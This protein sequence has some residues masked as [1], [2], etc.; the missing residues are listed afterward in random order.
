M[1]ILCPSCFEE[2]ADNAVSCFACATILSSTVT[3][4]SALQAGTLL[5]QGKYKIEKVLDQGGFGITY[6]GIYLQNSVHVAIKE[7]W[8]EAGARQ[9]SKVFWPNSIAP[10]DKQKQIT[11]FQN[12]ASNVQKCSH[13]HIVKVYDWFQENDTAYMVM[14]LLS[15]KPLDKI[16]KEEGILEENRAKHYLLQI[17]DALKVIHANNLLHR[18]IKPGNIIIVPPDNAVLIDFGAAREFIIAGKTAR[19]TGILTAGYAPY[20]Q[21]LSKAQRFPATDFY[22]LC[23][24]MYELLTGKL[25]AE[26]GERAD[27]LI[28]KRPDPF[29]SPRQLNPNLS[30][31]IEK[32]IMTG[33]QFK[34]E[35]RFQTADE[36]IN[37]LNGKF[38]SPIQRKAHELVKQGKLVDAV[39]SYEKLLNNEPNNGQAALELALIQ[40]Y[41]DDKKA[42]LAA[43]KAIQL[44]QQDGRGYGVLG[45]VSCR[46]TNWVE[47]VKYLQQAANLSPQESWIQAN[48]AWALGKSGNWQ[49]AKI[50]VNQALSI[51]ANCTFALGLQAWIYVKQ[52]QWK[53]AVRAA[54]Q[55][56]F[57]LKQ[58]PLTNSKESQKWIYPYLI[59][60]L[61]KAVITQ[62]AN[63]VERRIQ[64]FLAQ[65]P[66]SS[67][68]WGLSGW[69]KAKYGLW[70]DALSSF[71]QASRKTQVPSW[72][73][74]NYGITQENL[75]NLQGAIQIYQIYDQK[76]P[77]HAFV[78]FRLGT[79]YG[80]LGQWTQARIHLEKA[81][82]LNPN[83]AQAYH[84]LGWVLL[85][86]KNQDGQVENLREM[87][88]VYRKASELYTHQQK[89]SFATSIQQSF[90]LVGMNL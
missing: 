31:L 52:Q 29:V 17:A 53:P 83:Y 3:N 57:K 21:R 39:Q 89:S 30:P 12:E 42:E 47:A 81:I 74:I 69:K 65:V 5:G 20:E 13:P 7:L 72:V 40:M 36:L 77:P 85:N 68:A 82:H 71:E 16:L 32:V 75:Q 2:N 88:S 79:L 26:A 22:A 6:K 70:N 50:A 37:A 48:L 67:V 51:D 58:A 86:I 38:I 87:L 34:V 11:E 61:E 76:L 62:Q 33:M 73:L 56:V 4:P 25:P 78:C 1:T 15:G 28:N 19:M 55:A 45:L 18:D 23:A 8:P 43:Q 10:V 24:S 80:K 49:Q 44:Q 60:A 63:D 35:D 46:R 90:Q 59:F 84:N 54:T 27:A 66:D 14:D 9:G 64:E 41:I